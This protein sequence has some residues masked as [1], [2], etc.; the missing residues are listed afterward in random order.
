MMAQNPNR[1]EQYGRVPQ[2]TGQEF[3]KA[4]QYHICSVVQES[5]K[6]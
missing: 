4:S 5:N 1:G 2:G 6:E 3:G